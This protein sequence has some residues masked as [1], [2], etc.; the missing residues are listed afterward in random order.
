M[1]RLERGYITR[2]NL[3]VDQL[4]NEAYDKKW[5]YRDLASAAGL[6]DKTVRRIELRKTRVPYLR[7]VWKMAEALGLNI[8]IVDQTKP[9]LKI[10]R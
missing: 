10:A 3:I 5:D 4:F 1:K 2:L 6:A 7:T 9:K 8:D